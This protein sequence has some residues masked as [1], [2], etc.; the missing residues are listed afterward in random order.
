MVTDSVDIG[1]D[2]ILPAA[3]TRVEHRLVMRVNIF[4][5]SGC[6]DQV[7]QTTW[8]KQQKFVSHCPGGWK[9]MIRDGEP[10]F[11][12]GLSPLLVDRCLLPGSSPGLL[13]VSVSV[14]GS[15]PLGRTSATLDDSPAHPTDL[16]LLSLPL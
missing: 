10:S 4:T 5:R 9:S 2:R 13:H 12:Q 6:H 11:F 15:L 7:L 8:L 3:R 14:S 16:I 1:C